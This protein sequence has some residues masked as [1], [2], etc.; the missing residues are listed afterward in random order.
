MTVV[1]LVVAAILLFAAGIGIGLAVARA[2]GGGRRRAGV[3]GTGAGGVAVPASWARSHDPE[4]RLHRRIRQVATALAAL[5]ADGVAA[6]VRD[7]VERAAGALDERLVAVA[8]LPER[9]KAEPLAHVT[10]EVEGL[11]E[12]VADVTTR[13]AAG[14]D[15]QPALQALA[16]RLALLDA[17]RAELD[18]LAPGP[19]PSPAPGPEWPPPA[20][21]PA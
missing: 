11:E 4:A 3:A 5:P 21:P 16:E 18:S 19:S 1:F 13:T 15:I 10:R 12:A 20:S 9:V 7:K 17:A 14:G 8:A 2:G 6:D